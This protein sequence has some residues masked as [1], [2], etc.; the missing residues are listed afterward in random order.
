ML[1]RDGIFERHESERRREWRRE[2]WERCVCDFCFSRLS[3]LSGMIMM[4][5]V[6]DVV[7]KVSME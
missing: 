4:M 1:E 3:T 5:K 7:E 2:R 6:Y